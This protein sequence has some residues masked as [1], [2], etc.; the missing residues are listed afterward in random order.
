MKIKQPKGVKPKTQGHHTSAGLNWRRVLKSKGA[1]QGF[2]ALLS[3]RLTNARLANVSVPPAIS[4]RSFSLSVEQSDS[5]S[6][7]HSSV[8]TVCLHII[9]LFL[10]RVYSTYISQQDAQNSCDYTL[11][12]IRCSTCFGLY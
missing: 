8:P 7:G 9:P 2:G 5:V 4:N 10:D 11:F 3:C 1:K 12:S 6:F